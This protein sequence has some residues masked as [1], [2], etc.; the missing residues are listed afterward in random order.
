MALLDQFFAAL[1]AGDVDGAVGLLDDRVV[2]LGALGDRVEGKDAA[3]AYY[4]RLIGQHLTLDY[5]HKWVV[6]EDRIVALYNLGLDP[7]R[8]P[9]SK[10]PRRLASFT[11]GTVESPGSPRS[12]CRRA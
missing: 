10:A 6:G 1:N 4:D 11:F 8:A 9:I 12:S 7:F 2:I 5:L 3:H